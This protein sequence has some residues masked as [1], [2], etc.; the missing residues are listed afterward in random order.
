M[1]HELLT[2]NLKGTDFIVDVNKLEFR[3]KADPSNIIRFEDMLDATKRNSHEDFSISESVKKDPEDMT[4]KDKINDKTDFELLIDQEDVIRR[5]RGAL[6][7]VDIADHIFY[8]DLMMDKMRPHDDFLSNGI[9]FE[10]IEHYFSE[11]DDAY[12]I[13]YNPETHEFQEF[14]CDHDKITEFPKDLIAVK[15]P[16]QDKL[17]PIGWNMKGGFKLSDGLRE[18]GLQAHFVAKIIPWG[19]TWVADIIKENLERQHKP[20]KIKTPDVK[21]VPAKEQKDNRRKMYDY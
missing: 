3:E 11:E 21:P 1:E 4:R 12:I 5:I 7:T 8:V 6:P 13:P 14:E 2:V 18:T 15:F 10:E 19:E 20:E 16:F 9:V 17:D